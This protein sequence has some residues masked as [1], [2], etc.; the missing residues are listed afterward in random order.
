MTSADDEH[1]LDAACGAACA[2]ACSD[3]LRAVVGRD[4]LDALG[5]AA[6]RSRSSRSFTASITR[7]RVLAVAHDHDAADHLALAVELGEA[8]PDVRPEAD[9]RDVAHADRRAAAS[10]LHRARARGPSGV[11]HVAAAADH[12]LV[13]RDLEH[14]A[15]RRPRST[16]ARRATTSSQRDAVAAQLVGI[17]AD[18]VLLDEAADRRDLG[19][20]G[21]ARERV[22]Q[23]PVLERAQLC[24]SCLPLLSTSAYSNTQP[25][26][27]ASGP[28]V[29]VD[30]LRAA[31]A[32]AASGTRARGCAPSRCPCRP[33]RSR[34][35]TTCPNIDWPRTDLHL[36]RREQ[37][38][39]DRDR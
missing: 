8:A 15:R 3:Q 11:V 37:R 5:Q 7:E 21:H 24:R 1:L 13:P 9:R 31:R 10:T 27:V 6:L 22:A 28:S 25:T 4:D 39:R 14:A 35:R 17:D 20:A 16:R 33:R 38:G 2:T 36:R 12:V 34:R 30:A 23:V 29:G 32:C 19:D 26:P 18:L